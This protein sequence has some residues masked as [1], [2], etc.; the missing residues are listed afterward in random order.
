MPW[1]RREAAR[2]FIT[3]TMRLGFGSRQCEASGNLEQFRPKVPF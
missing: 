1:K 2:D 3:V